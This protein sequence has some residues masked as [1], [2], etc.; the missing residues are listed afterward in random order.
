[1]MPSIQLKE[2][3][4]REALSQNEA[5]GPVLTEDNWKTP[6]DFSKWERRAAP[7]FDSAKTHK[8]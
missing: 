7:H 2:K 4:Q 3:R 8:F 1:M 6:T 5:T